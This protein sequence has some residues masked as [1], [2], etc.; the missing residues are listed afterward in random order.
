[1]KKHLQISETKFSLKFK[2]F[3]LPILVT[4]FAEEYSEKEK[5]HSD[6]FSLQ[7]IIL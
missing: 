2:K 4:F 6:I 7:V 5:S 1:M 3:C